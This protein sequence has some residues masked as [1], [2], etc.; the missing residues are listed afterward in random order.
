MRRAGWIAVVLMVAAWVAA[1]NVVNAVF[2]ADPQ[3]QPH[4]IAGHIG[5][6]LPAALLWFWLR[7]RRGADGVFLVTNRVFPQLMLVGLALFS[8]G[9]F[10]EATSAALGQE[11]FFHVT[12]ETGWAL[13]ALGMLA[14]MV[15]LVL[16]VFLQLLRAKT[17]PGLSGE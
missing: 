15:S 9:G 3:T 2:Q 4:H 11:G 5:L 7:A 10:V 8:I 12:H 14:L 1:I 6:A 16:A 17:Q 13:N